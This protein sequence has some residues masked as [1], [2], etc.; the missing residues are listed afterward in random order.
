MSSKRKSA[1]RVPTSLLYLT[2]LSLSVKAL[3]GEGIVGWNGGWSKLGV[4][5]LNLLGRFQSGGTLNAV[6]GYCLENSL[7]RGNLKGI[8]TETLLSAFRESCLL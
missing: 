4:L 1:C 2:G 3:S 5:E 7:I 8:Q 6:G